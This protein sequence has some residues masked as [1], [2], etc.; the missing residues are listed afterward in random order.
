MKDSLVFLNGEIKKPEE[1]NISIFDRGFLFGDSIY[2]V[3]IS[4]NNKLLFF[5]EHLDRL[6]NSA[7][8]IDLEIEYKRDEIANYA[9]SLLKEFGCDNAYI[10]IIITRGIDNISLN[11]DKNI[12]Q[13]LVMIAKQAPQYEESLYK[14]GIYLNLAERK[15]NDREALD[16]NAKSGNYLNNIL[17][18]KEAKRNN[19]YDAIMEN[20]QGEVTE[21]TT[22]N[23]W[24]VKDNHIIT[25]HSKSGLLEGITRRKFY[26]Q[27]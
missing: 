11:P 19:A 8:L 20:M 3:T 4:I 9:M 24:Y 1:A 10:R 25:P 14:K 17:A 27:A 12:K 15:R 23:I 22:F 18:I 7:S 13:N 5:D 26:M 6:Y 2:E 21:G 16:P